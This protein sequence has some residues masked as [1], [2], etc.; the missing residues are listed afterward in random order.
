LLCRTQWNIG[1]R[2]SWCERGSYKEM[3]NEDFRSTSILV[4]ET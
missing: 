2:F 4:Y 3:G 1:I